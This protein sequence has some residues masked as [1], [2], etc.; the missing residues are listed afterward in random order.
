MPDPV[1][2]QVQKQTLKITEAL[3]IFQRIERPIVTT[4]NTLHYSI[5]TIISFLHKTRHRVPPPNELNYFLEC[6][7]MDEGDVRETLIKNFFPSEHTF[8]WDIE[9]TVSELEFQEII[10][11]NLVSLISPITVELQYA[12][13]KENKI[14]KSSYNT[15]R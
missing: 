8:K 7:K 14:K 4:S 9:R 12:I 11:N 2:Y 13:D 1:A 15:S 6:L 5:R 3:I 10:S